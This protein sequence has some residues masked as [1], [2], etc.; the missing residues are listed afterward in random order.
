MALVALAALGWALPLYRLNRRLEQSERQYRELAENAPFPVAINE[1]DTGRVLFANRRADGLFAGPAASLVGRPVDDLFED[2]ADRERLLTELRA[3][4]S[5]TDLEVCLR[6]GDRKFWTLL[7]AGPVEF[8]GNRGLFVAFHDIT[9]RH[10]IEEELRRA[11]DAAEAA[12][13]SKSHYLAVMTHEVRTPL[14][15]IIGLA[16]ILQ[17]QPLEP[18]VRE[19]VRL[20]ESTGETLNQLISNILD[21]SRIEAGRLDVER[22]P[23]EAA[24]LLHE[25][26]RLFATSAQTKKLALRVN[27]DPEVPPVVLTDP[28]R[29]RQIL[30][31]LLSNAIK[32]TAQGGVELHVSFPPQTDGSIRLRFSVQDTGVG[33]APERVALLFQP[34][35]QADNSVA[36][37]YGGTGLGLAISRDLA[38]LLGG[39]LTLTSVPGQGTTFILEIPVGLPVPG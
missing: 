25:L 12:N 37:R 15:G 30:S 19:H 21:Y 18:E 8:A 24:G 27:L 4:R 33:I 29:L 36:R 26:S 5:V 13:V 3:G 20:I 35:A 38:R 10:A 14:S 2:P 1:L 22:I 6:V 9:A 31:N 17:E 32:F 11:K 39:D 34:Y 23:L 16:G 28:A 7:S